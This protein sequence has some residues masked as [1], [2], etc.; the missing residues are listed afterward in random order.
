MA[1]LRIPSFRAWAMVMEG[2][3]RLFCPSVPIAGMGRPLVTVV[4][5]PR[6]LL[7]SKN[8][9]FPIRAAAMPEGPPLSLRLPSHMG[10][11][12]QGV[13]SALSRPPRYSQA[14]DSTPTLLC[15]GCRVGLRPGWHC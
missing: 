5:A 1:F 6:R 12:P 7:T 15:C 10:R 9:P 11:H 3:H 8:F 13:A 2:C 4:D 14:P